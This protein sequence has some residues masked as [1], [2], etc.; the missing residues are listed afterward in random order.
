MIAFISSESSRDHLELTTPL[1]SFSQI[2]FQW[3]V[4]ALVT[5]RQIICHSAIS[6]TPTLVRVWSKTS[7]A[8]KVIYISKKIPVTQ[9]LASQ[10]YLQL[11]L[12][13]PIPFF[14]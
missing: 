8:T 12:K 13:P 9:I 14:L 11:L 1:E 3:N 2:A 5:N 4:S 6:Y 10:K 7:S